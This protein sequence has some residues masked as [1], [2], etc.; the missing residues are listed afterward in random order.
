MR[1]ESAPRAPTPGARQRPLEGGRSGGDP[2]RMRLSIATLGQEARRTFARFPAVLLCGLGAA[3]L[4]I[5]L[6]N[7]N[8]P[9]DGSVR[10]MLVL[11]LGIPL[12]LALR[13]LLEKP[14]WRGPGSPSRTVSIAVVLGGFALLAAYRWAL[15]RGEGEAA[16]LRYLQ[17]TFAAELFVAIAAFLGRG[18]ANGF[19]QFNRR[20][21]LRFFLSGIYA[22]V[23]FGGLAAAI[24]AVDR[25]FDVK[26]NNVIYP[27]L[28]FFTVLVFLPWH[29]LAGVPR[30]LAAL[31]AD[32]EHPKGLRLFT[33][34]LLLPLVVLYL[35]ILYAYTAKIVLTRTWPQGWVGWLVSAA[36]I[37][38][39]LTILLL[40]PGRPESEHRWADR[41]ARAYFAAIIPLLGLLFA[42]LGKRVGQYGVTEKRYWL[43]VL[44]AWLCGIALFMLFG[45]AHTLKAIPATLALVAIVTSFGPWGAYAVSLRSQSA[46]LTALLSRHG[47]LA[48]GTLLRATTEVPHQDVR[49]ISASVDYL[50]STHGGRSLRRWSDLKGGG[51]SRALFA[52]GDDNACRNLFLDQMGL[53]YV[54]PWDVDTPE[55]QYYAANSDGGRDVSGYERIYDCYFM[56]SAPGSTYPRHW[57]RFD[58]R[59]SAVEILD[60]SAVLL[61]MPLQPLFDRLEALPVNSAGTVPPADLCV[62]GASEALRARACFVSLT[63]GRDDP[64]G[65][66]AS[67]GNGYILIDE[68]P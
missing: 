52:G 17:V 11:I 20:L 43:F 54:P 21:F 26:V 34:Y 6:V 15:G 45:R 62:A 10:T 56:R 24:L 61:T 36:S 47:L 4:A 60:G 28:W 57:G 13:L 33:Q 50:A 19:W 49:E 30:D 16:F 18:E 48:N 3:W 53:T 58:D 12:F 5:D 59:G 37:F 2:H 39:V 65:R 1:L 7:D 14:P 9:N 68:H 51:I 46:R 67:T 32:S 27:R 29:F 42:A 38:G 35:A 63:L 25:L 23:F 41:F 40:Q 8:N 55:V 22:A 66:A 64:A 31:E 44:G